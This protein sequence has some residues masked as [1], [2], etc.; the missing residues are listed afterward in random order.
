MFKFDDKTKES[1]VDLAAKVGKSLKPTEK[2]IQ[3]MIAMATIPVILSP[4]VIILANRE[5]PVVDPEMSALAEISFPE[6]QEAISNP[7]TRFVRYDDADRLDEIHGLMLNGEAESAEYRRVMAMGDAADL[8]NEVAQDGIFIKSYSCNL[9]ESGNYSCDLAIL[10]AG[11][12]LADGA[13][14]DYNVGACQMRYYD[15][16]VTPAEEG[17]SVTAYEGTG[18]ISENRIAEK[19]ALAARVDPQDYTEEAPHLGPQTLED[20]TASD[21]AKFH[22]Y[23]FKLGGGMWGSLTEDQI[24]AERV[25]ASFSDCLV[26]QPE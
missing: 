18:R 21:H 3:N 17:Y 22:P 14:T 25:F 9:E 1:L 2:T 19:Y 10:E 12:V 4:L 5:P 24:A 23:R 7:G 20:I 6:I 13:S 8:F 11:G 16:T 26:I 15:V